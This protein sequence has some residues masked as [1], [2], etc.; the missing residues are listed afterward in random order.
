MSGQQSAQPEPYRYE[1][2]RRP[3]LELD[4]K[5][6]NISLIVFSKQILML[7]YNKPVFSSMV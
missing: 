2:G 1:E 4:F 5:I 7:G 6:I 3:C